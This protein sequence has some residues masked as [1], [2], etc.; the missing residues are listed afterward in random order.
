MDRGWTLDDDDVVNTAVPINMRILND[1][2]KTYHHQ[3]S[4]TS[5]EIRHKN[6]RIED[7]RL[8][9]EEI[10]SLERIYNVSINSTPDLR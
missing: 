2:A 8:L 6:E 1:I 5:I 10:H 4:Q 9:V 3:A 7:L